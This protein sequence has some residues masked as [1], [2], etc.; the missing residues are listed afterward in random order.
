MA[1]T[2]LASRLLLL[3]T[4]PA[5]RFLV[6]SLTLSRAER[7]WL[8]AP[9]VLAA[10]GLSAW[11]GRQHEAR[12]T[13]RRNS[14]DLADHSYVFTV[15]FYEHPILCGHYT[16]Q[17]GVAERRERLHCGHAVRDRLNPMAGSVL[18]PRL[19]R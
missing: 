17:H 5:L 3:V 15:Q 6:L 11:A 16:L 19:T 7:G 14:R 10:L 2:C 8:Y 13:C 9:F 4:T 12:R 1:M 18:L